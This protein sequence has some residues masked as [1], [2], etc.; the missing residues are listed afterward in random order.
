[1]DKTYRAINR[2]W[3]TPPAIDRMDTGKDWA[4]LISLLHQISESER[5]RYRALKG[6]IC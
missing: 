6:M 1:M 5:D 3:V 2:L 4:S